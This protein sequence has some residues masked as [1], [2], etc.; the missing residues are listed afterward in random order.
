[1]EFVYRGENGGG[2]TF[3]YIPRRYIH[4]SSCSHMR[5]SPKAA[6]KH[7]FV[8]ADKTQASIRLAVRTIR[9]MRKNKPFRAAGRIIFALLCAVLCST[10]SQMI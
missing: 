2:E 7:P 9:Y 1:M 6:V 8:Q 5:R 10:L 3:M 4:Y